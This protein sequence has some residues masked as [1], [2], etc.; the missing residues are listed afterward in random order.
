MNL[1]AILVFKNAINR[2]HT[3]GNLLIEPKVNKIDQTRAEISMFALF[4]V[5]VGGAF[6]NTK[7][8]GAPPWGVFLGLFST[9][10]CT[11]YTLLH[12]KSR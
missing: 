3:L 10:K 11:E 4:N 2:F 6:F 8:G 5:S 12:I 7:R 1:A 9:L